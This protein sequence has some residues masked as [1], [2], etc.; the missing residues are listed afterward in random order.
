MDSGS[1]SNMDEDSSKW[2]QVPQAHIDC[3]SQC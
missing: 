1:S 2:W 3:S